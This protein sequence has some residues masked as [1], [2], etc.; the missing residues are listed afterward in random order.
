[1]FAQIATAFVRIKDGQFC[2][3]NI[4][5]PIVGINIGIQH[6][7]PPTFK[8]LHNIG[9]NAV[10]VSVDD[11]K[12]LKPILKIA[13]KN[14]IYL[15]IVLN[16]KADLQLVQKYT[17]R[18]EILAWETSTMQQAQFIKQID[19]N[20][21]VCTSAPE[22]LYTRNTHKR[23]QQERSKY[24]D[25]L[26]LQLHPL[27]YKW[28]SPTS[29]YM[30]LNNA[31][32]QTTSYV[33]ELQRTASFNNKPLVV[34]SCSYPRDKMFRY[35]GSTTLN[36]NAYFSTVLYMTKKQ[37]NDA[38]YIAGCFFTQW[39]MPSEITDDTPKNTA[40]QSIYATDSATISLLQ[41]NKVIINK[42]TF[43]RHEKY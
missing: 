31:F 26:T 34:T 8:L 20:H 6:A 18:T 32:L 43:Y 23:E 38:P 15:L 36:R 17:K 16:E 1:M 10:R 11:L 4:P 25:F 19:A 27:D 33:N 5:T 24:I 39:A 13:R 29:L 41:K 40:T 14:H 21:L 3:N 9:F 37:D 30:G 12:Q 42:Q 2:A 7:N 28:V 35:E 22:E